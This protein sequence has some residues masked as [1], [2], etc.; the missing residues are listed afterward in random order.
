MHTLRVNRVQNVVALVDGNNLARASELLS[1]QEIVR[2]NTYSTCPVYAQGA[3]HPKMLLLAG[4]KNGLLLIGSGNLSSSGLSTN[5]EIWAAFQLSDSDNNNAFIFG[6]AWAYFNN[7]SSSFR[8]TNSKKLEW[9][10]KY[11]PWLNSLPTD[12]NLG[13]IKKA[14]AWFLANSKD[15]SIFDQVVRVIPKHDIE[16]IT[17]ISPYYDE[18]GLF[19]VDLHTHFEPEEMHCCVDIESGLLPHF[20]DKDWK[21]NINFHDWSEVRK[22]FDSKFNR[23]HA[24]LIHFNTSGD[25]EYL[26][27]GSANATIAG[28][29]GINKRAINDEVNLLI[30]RN[31]SSD[32][33]SQLAINIS[34]S[35]RI[36]IPEKK[37]NKEEKEATSSFSFRIDYVEINQSTLTLYLG[38]S[39]VNSVSVGLVDLQGSTIETIETLVEEHVVTV[40]C[41]S[42]VAKSAVRLYFTDEKDNRISNFCLIHSVEAMERS[43]PDPSKARI[44]K[45][46]NKTEFTSK[47]WSELLNIVS[48]SEF[49]DQTMRSSSMY[50]SGGG[51]KK[52]N[53]EDPYTETAEYV[54]T[55]KEEFNKQDKDHQNGS[56]STV[57]YSGQIYSFL[58]DYGKSILDNDNFEES[59][60]QKLGQNPDSGGKG[61]Q[62]GDKKYSSTNDSSDT[63]RSIISYLNKI[64]RHYKKKINRIDVQSEDTKLHKVGGEALKDVL[65]ALQLVILFKERKYEEEVEQKSGKEII[66]KPYFE[67]GSLGSGNDTIKGFLLSVMGKFSYIC[68]AMGYVEYN[69][70][71]QQESLTALRMDV[72]NKTM[73]LIHEVS[74]N[75]MP[76]LN[77]RKLLI[78]NILEYI[79]PNSD[80]INFSD[81]STDVPKIIQQRTEDTFDEYWKWK[82]LYLNP[83]LK[84]STLIRELRQYSRNKFLFHGEVGFALLEK[85]VKMKPRVNV[86]LQHPAFK[87]RNNY[88]KKI[89]FYPKIVQFKSN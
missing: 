15:A 77:M 66:S 50:S 59:E 51:S 55:T 73:L 89:N 82:K 19:L 14:K 8:G 67:K 47:D 72:F 9:V 71:D 63:Q 57:N 2:G 7:L 4:K 58:S 80:D 3:F 64:E 52:E 11:A 87:K 79:N 78:L 46:L 34:S 74:W 84:K 32:W 23:L 10:S 44:T 81:F 20:L 54:T 25:T 21:Q 27:F 26:L 75:R 65:I 41:S 86:I 68:R 85:V 62:V 30:R 53:K 49:D 28:M 22:D 38:K 39:E 83:E 88:T 60:E 36:T 24:K 45:L 42:S 43:N 5:D 61:G 70:G 33:L 40:K 37:K 12:Q 29:G 13:E 31:T 76:E 6:A 69:N 16:T 56:I 48:L 17:V 35:S 18:K 1:G